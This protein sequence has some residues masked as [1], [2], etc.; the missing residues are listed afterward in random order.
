MPP[1]RRATK[2]LEESVAAT[3]DVERDVDELVKRLAKIAAAENRRPPE[4]PF[5]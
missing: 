3:P 5:R 2:A 4:T 1:L